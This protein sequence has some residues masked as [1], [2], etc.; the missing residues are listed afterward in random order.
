MKLLDSMDD[1][2]LM[3]APR[4][5]VEPLPVPLIINLAPYIKTIKLQNDTGHTMQGKNIHPNCIATK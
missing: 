5:V 1:I 2:P 4:H 3:N